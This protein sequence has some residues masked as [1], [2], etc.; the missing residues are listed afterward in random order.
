MKV[1]KS[2]LLF[3]LLI[4]LFN[5]TGIS[6]SVNTKDPYA[7]ITSAYE[8]GRYPEAEKLLRALLGKNPSDVQALSLL[9]VVLDAQ[10]K[11]G[12]AEKAYLKAIEFAPTSAALHNNLGNHYLSQGD[13]AKAQQAFQRTIK[14]KPRHHNANLQLAV[15]L[16]DRKEFA[17]AD[18]RLK[19]LPP[20]ELANPPVQILQARIYHG[21]GQ[22]KEAQ[23]ILGP[24]E[25][26]AL[27]DLRLEFSL[28]L[29][30]AAMER[31]QEAEEAF[32]AV[33]RAD[34]TNFE[35]L[36]NLGTAALRANNLER[37]VEAL[38]RAL[39]QR[40][41]DV[42]CMV[43]LART[44]FQNKQNAQA[45]QLLVR[46]NLRAP[47]RADILLFMAQASYNEGF[48]AD[49]VIAYDKYLKLRPNDDTALREKGFALARSFGE[50]EG[51]QI[52]EWYV[53]KYPKDPWGYYKLAAAQSS[54][55]PESSLQ[56]I[57]KLL[58]MDPNFHEAL[59]AR[60]VLYLK[61]NRP[62]E[63]IADLKAFLEH[64]PENVQAQDQ[65]G[66]ALIKIDQPQAAAD[67][68]QKA[69]KQ[70]PENGDLYF[71]YSRALRL[72]GRT[73]EMTEALA[74]FKQ[75]GSEQQR[76][77][78]EPG[79]FDYLSLS[80]DE[81]QARYMSTLQ[82]AIEQRPSDAD[83]K[84]Q[85]AEMYFKQQKTAEAISLI[86]RACQNQQNLKTLAQAGN[87]LLQYGQYG[88]ALPLLESAAQQEDPSEEI[89][90]NLV[91]ALFHSKGADA[92]LSRL[93][94]WDIAHRNGNYYLLRAQILDS[95]GKLPDAVNS[96]NRA[97]QAAPSRPDLFREAV[98]FLVKHEKFDEALNLLT[99]SEKHVVHDP[100]LMLMKA[101]VL[102]F[103]KFND[104]AARQLSTMESLWP[105]WY[106][107]YLIH[108]IILQNQRQAKESKQ[109][110]ETAIALGGKEP[111]TYFYLSLAMKDLQPK[112]DAEAY[113]VVKQA[114]ELNPKDPYFQ[115]HAGKLATNMKDYPKALAHLQE[116]IRLSPELVDAH[117]NLAGLY[118]AMG[119]DS[120]QKAEL[121]EVNRLY[122]L[123]PPG[124]QTPLPMR[125]LLFNVA[126]PGIKQA[127]GR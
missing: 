33:L 94:P 109:L 38:Q 114:L 39:Q 47:Q 63:A 35:I 57:N 34:P 20:A 31:F 48:Y 59:Y 95:A 107:P 9:G 68:F 113:K 103:L 25:A 32:S 3:G 16:A 58:A 99:Q 104:D 108:G 121:D 119:E 91:L 15:I 42:D 56:S 78:P 49:T 90:L 122:K 44:F 43:G 62:Q 98:L 69:I 55:A 71:H 105:E 10:K 37:A 67:V 74:R 87:L 7:S 17:A 18:R 126:S 93:D 29:A 60:G 45:L 89:L 76:N 51:I 124:E 30:Y 22:K 52:L 111:A 53:K 123:H 66:R 79:L 64:N 24:L 96:L 80:P 81:Q 21:M 65:L 92:A 117:W 86:D 116:A 40:P 101:I 46:A 84:I 112:E 83:L 50:K 27:T 36:Y 72:L 118:R 13:I 6:Q 61:L 8:Q 1:F 77:V 75:L 97:L 127:G 26:Q 4:C 19:I 82:R 5:G 85:L 28:G 41:D 88:P 110:L 73:K 102:E 54:V 23:K 100:N 125:D 106:L 115:M 120:K 70:S 2:F 11:F 12:E 14:L